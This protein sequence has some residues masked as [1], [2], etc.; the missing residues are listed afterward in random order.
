MLAVCWR[1]CR[2]LRARSARRELNLRIHTFYNDCFVLSVEL[3][4]W[5]HCRSKLKQSLNGTVP[6]E[7]AP[8]GRDSERRK[9]IPLNGD[10]DAPPVHQSTRLA[11]FVRF[12]QALRKQ[13][14]AASAWQ[15]GGKVV[16]GGCR[17]SCCCSAGAG[18]R[19]QT[20]HC[21]SLSLTRNGTR[22]RHAAAAA[23][24]WH[25]H[26]ENVWEFFAAQP[27][28]ANLSLSISLLPS[29]NFV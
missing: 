22:Q 28:C 19:R 12:V 23:T 16:A 21:A 26:F 27:L 17:S 11:T 13:F 20:G 8:A 24:Q 15:L 5:K 25:I 3:K 1:V 14:S 18:R 4:H 2:H 6:H 10:R 29:C 9:Y 7:Y